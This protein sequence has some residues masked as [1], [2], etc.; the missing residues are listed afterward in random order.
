MNMLR[1]RKN[2]TKHIESKEGQRNFLCSNKGDGRC[3]SLGFNSNDLSEDMA[4][5]IYA[6]LLIRAALNQIRNERK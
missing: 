3:P 4:L 6:R 2:H 1:K 5:D